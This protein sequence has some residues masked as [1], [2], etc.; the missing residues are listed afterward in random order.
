MVWKPPTDIVANR[1]TKFSRNGQI[2]II[3]VILNHKNDRLQDVRELHKPFSRGN[4]GI[5]EEFERRTV[6]DKKIN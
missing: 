5:V 6:Q 1:Q 3:E 2:T 4:A